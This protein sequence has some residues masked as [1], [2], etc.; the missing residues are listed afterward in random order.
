MPTGSPGAA[1]T[2][3]QRP[4]EHLPDVEAGRAHLDPVRRVAVDRTVH[5]CAV[6]NEAQ[7]RRTEAERRD[8]KETGERDQHHFHRKDL[9][10]IA[11][12]PCRRRSEHSV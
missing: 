4:V 7:C 3:R 5:L 8:E 11:A 2:V 9:I 12:A 10:S 6:R 1:H